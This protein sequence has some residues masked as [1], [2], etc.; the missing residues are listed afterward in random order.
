METILDMNSLGIKI[1]NFLLIAHSYQ[2]TAN[3]YLNE[4]GT[5][6]I[7]IVDPFDGLSQEGSHG[8]DPDFVQ[9]GG[10]RGERNGVGDRQGLDHGTLE[11]AHRVCL[12]Y[13]S[14]A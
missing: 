1:R 3:S 9:G 4:K 8:Q 13:T 14:D 2:L 12:L 10:L 11:V 5:H 7:L 6:G